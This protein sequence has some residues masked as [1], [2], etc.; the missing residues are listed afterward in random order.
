[1][2]HGAATWVLGAALTSDASG[3]ATVDSWTLG[4]SVGGNALAGS[5]AGL[6]G[7][8]ITFVATGTAGAAAAIAANTGNN[9]L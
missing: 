1:M 3:I 7:S 5:S 8:P 2:R 4:P 6:T 9:Q